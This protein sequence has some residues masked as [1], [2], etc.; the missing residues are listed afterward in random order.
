MLT[1]IQRIEKKLG[2]LERNAAANN[3]S[4]LQV[5]LKSI[6]VQGSIILKVYATDP[7]PA[8]EGQIA[9]VSGKLKV[10]TVGGAS[11]TWVVVGT[12]T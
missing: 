11:P 8:R 6:E 9:Y 12:Q 2:D 4:S 3:F 1:D 5:F 10:C 7:I